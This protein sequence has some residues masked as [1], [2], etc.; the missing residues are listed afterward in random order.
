MKRI[1]IIG[2]LSLI[3]AA[4]SSDVRQVLN[5]AKAETDPAKSLAIIRHAEDAYL[6]KCGSVMKCSLPEELEKADQEYFKNAAKAG[7]ERV[8]REL[9]AQRNDL[10]ELK[11]ELKPEV[12][13]RA[14]D[15]KNVD[16]LVAAASIAGD[17]LLGVVN[18]EQQI[19]FLK[20]AWEAGDVKSA[21]KLALIYVWLKAFDNA[22][23]WSLRCIQDCNRSDSTKVREYVNQIELLE[24][25]KHLDA[26]K[27]AKLQ[28]AASTK[29][30][31]E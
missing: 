22:Y 13:K 3:L 18:K 27:I 21:G 9:F 19:Q 31:V 25:E 2:V 15:S 8:L 26:N 30:L 12:L 1:I 16:L 24:L 28:S 23:F 29:T 20:R 7:N 5:Q 11:N 17:D 4:C 14:K 10:T 6:E